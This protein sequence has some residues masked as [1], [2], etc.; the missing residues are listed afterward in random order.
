LIAAPASAGPDDISD[1]RRYD[2]AAF[3]TAHNAFAATNLGWV[4]A[5]QK[6][7]IGEQLAFGVRGFML[8]IYQS[9]AG[10]VQKQCHTVRKQIK[11][12]EKQC[13]KATKQNCGPVKKAE[14]RCHRWTDHVCKKAPWP[15]N[16]LC[17][18]V[19]KVSCGTVT[20]TKTVCKNVQ[21][22]ACSPVT[23]TSWV[24]Q[25]VCDG[26]KY[27]VPDGPVRARLCHEHDGKKAKDCPLTRNVERPLQSPQ[28][29]WTALSA[30][31]HYLDRNRRAII[32]IMFESY[33]D[34]KG[35][36]DAQF[37]HSGI[38][39]YVFDPRKHDVSNKGWPTI[40]WMRKSN[41]RLVVLTGGGADGRPNNW[42]YVV[43][44]QYDLGKYGNCEVRGE[45]EKNIK[46][47]NVTLLTM[48]HFYPIAAGQPWVP[49]GN[50]SPSAINNYAWLYK[51]AKKCRESVGR[52]PN[53]IA[54]DFVE[55]GQGLLL[56]EH[57]NQFP[58]ASFHNIK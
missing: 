51:R 20:V 12:T 39:R 16:Q 7:S 27:V 8:D 34:N 58:P 29:L 4:Y 17:K 11:K 23:L 45:T 30:I 5:Q 55:Q 32:T 38:N 47:K 18:G 3:L 37:N 1:N 36:V 9:R 35:M 54:L 21:Y 2:Q 6:L 28:E 53:F 49:V 13:H 22:V 14:R 40:G 52:V 44:T 19:S 33:V 31:K 24:N 41:K 57:I 50:L 42:D 26:S 25:Q 10:V 15:L 56:V 48:N 43:E 46:K